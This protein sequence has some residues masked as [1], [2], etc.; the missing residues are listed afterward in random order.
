[1]S[2]TTWADDYSSDEGSIDQ[3]RDQPQ[4]RNTSDER[5]VGLPRDTSSAPSQGPYV[6]AIANINYAASRKDVGVFFEKKGCKI[7]NLDLNTRPDGTFAGSA[8]MEFN[9]RDSMGLGLR[10]NGE[11]FMDKALR[12]KAWEE[13]PRRHLGAEGGGPHRDGRGRHAGGRLDSGGRSTG[14][15]H[16]QH[17]ENFRHR[18]QQEQRDYARKGRDFN[19][20]GPPRDFRDRGPA[21]DRSREGDH[22]VSKD[23]A[24]VPPAAERPRIVLQPRTLPLEDVGKVTVAPTSIFGAGKPQDETRY[25]VSI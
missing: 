20:S 23:P 18:Q 5:A 6:L 25:E 10:M 1:M 9:D 17:Q 4:Y 16:Y 19:Q 14:N 24:H 7:A 13:R 12:T 2:N 15:D 11:L 3:E 21:R 22:R 8:V